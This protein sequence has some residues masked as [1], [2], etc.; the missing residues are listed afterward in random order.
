[1]MTINIV[2]IILLL[3]AAQSLFLTALIFHKYK[4][5]YANRF[6]GSLILVYSVLLLHLLF[7]DLGYSDIYPH[8]TLLFIGIGFLIPPLQ[9][10]YAK[11]LVQ[12][13]KRSPEKL[14]GY[15]SCL[16][17]SMRLVVLLTSF[18]LVRKVFSHFSERNK[19]RAVI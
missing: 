12:E 17:S 2:E 14:I 8:F 10:L 6:L 1:M 13:V 18:N 7:G 11:F 4:S 5:L 9:Y 16:S 19:R 3:A 15:I